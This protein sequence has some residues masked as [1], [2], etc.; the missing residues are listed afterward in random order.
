MIS[1]YNWLLLREKSHIIFIA[2]SVKLRYHR[3][4]FRILRVYKNKLHYLNIK[5]SMLF[6]DKECLFINTLVKF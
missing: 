4:N 3:K 2:P 5:W 1:T 6:K